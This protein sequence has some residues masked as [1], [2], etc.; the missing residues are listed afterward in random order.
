MASPAKLR[1]REEPRRVAE[2]IERGIF[3]AGELLSGSP[4]EA[5]RTADAASGDM[6]SAE[7][8]WQ[9]ERKE[10]QR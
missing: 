5:Q 9:S 7:E 2:I 1:D 6:M 3:R 10:Q 8:R 4:N